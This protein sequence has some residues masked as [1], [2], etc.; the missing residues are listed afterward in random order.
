VLLEPS[1]VVI[2]AHIAVV[3]RQRSVARVQLEFSRD[4]RQS[5][6]II[7]FE[8]ILLER[9]REKGVIQPVK[10]IRFGRTA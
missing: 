6:G 3:H 10:D 8:Q 4:L 7:S 5:M 2:D 9:T 1:F